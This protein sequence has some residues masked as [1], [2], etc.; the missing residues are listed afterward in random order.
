MLPRSMTA[1][2][3]QR[4]RGTITREAI[5]GAALAIV[6]RAGV[7]GLTIRAVARQIGAPP[8]SLYSHFANKDELLDLMFCEIVRRLYPDQGNA[9]WQDELFE[10]CRHIRAELLAHPRWTA[11]LVRPVS[12]GPVAVRERILMLM[13]TDGFAPDVAFSALAGACLSAMGIALAELTLQDGRGAAAIDKRYE[14]VRD[15]ATSSKEAPQTKAA[16]QANPKFDHQ[17]VFDLAFRAMT[18]GLSAN[19][20]AVVQ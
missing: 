9:T 18:R 6:D 10:L 16:V 11:L 7:D 3:K 1:M 20:L 12:P 17:A 2:R 4:P 13:A 19:R 14:S 15:W 8:M 5:L